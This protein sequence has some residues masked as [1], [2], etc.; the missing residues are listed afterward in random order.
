MRNT[1]VEE[2][3]AR[4]CTSATERGAYVA[5]MCHT[6][7]IRALLTGSPLLSHKY[8]SGLR[9]LSLFELSGNALTKIPEYLEAVSQRYDL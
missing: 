8:E 9:Q 1:C 7:V 4:S 6:R 5:A 3:F 2:F